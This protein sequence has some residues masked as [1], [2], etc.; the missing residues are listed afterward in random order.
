MNYR[1]LYLRIGAVFKA[2]FFQQHSGQQ[3]G[4]QNQQPPQGQNHLSHQIQQLSG[5][6]QQQLQQT[7]QQLQQSI[8]QAI[9]TLKLLNTFKV[10]GH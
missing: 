5:Q 4:Q 1:V 7:D 6:T 10:I 3:T 8:Q 9:Q 2:A